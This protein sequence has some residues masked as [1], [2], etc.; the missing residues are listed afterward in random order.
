[1]LSLFTIIRVG[2]LLFDSQFL[3][4]FNDDPIIITKDE[5]TINEQFCF[6]Q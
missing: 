4:C 2:Q 1:M 6:R 5:T 3:D